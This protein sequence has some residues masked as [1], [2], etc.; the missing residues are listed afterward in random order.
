M[1][2]ADANTK[3]AEGSVD[4]R[5]GGGATAEV[6]SGFCIDD[7]AG[8]TDW[9]T[10]ADELGRWRQGHLLLGIPFAWL[11]PPGADPFTGE[12]QA[13]TELA[14]I[15]DSIGTP[16]IICTQTCD[17]G[18]TPPGNRHPFIHIAPLVR[19]DQ[20]ERNRSRLATDRKLGELV[21][22]RSPFADDPELGDAPEA[23]PDGKPGASA[24][25]G[26][27]KPDW[28]ADLRLQVPASKAILLGRD[29][30]EGFDCESGYV[31]FGEMLAYKL[32]RPALHAAL[33]EDFPK[34]LS[35]FVRTIGA[36]KQCF[37][38]VEQV[39][40]LMLDA[41]RLN[42]SRVTIYVLTNGIDL[43]DEEREVW[44]QFQSKAHSLL[45][46]HSIQ[47][48]SLLHCDIGQLYA[49]K[50]RLSVPVPCEAL[51]SLRFI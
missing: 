39:R 24:Q 32:R 33:S 42:P 5:P 6:L 10:Y 1:G 50:Y 15:F 4:A 31:E 45:K 3:A 34:L 43:T 14:P 47:L 11:A 16:G 48:A 27:V 2:P 9:A 26:G 49:D 22:V 37:T 36:K 21:P 38:K 29:P 17:L 25:K 28:F 19:R 40:L 12:E 46:P 13:A 35:E 8:Q 7:A 41:D 20:L 44:A 51:N 23:N 18:G 30:I